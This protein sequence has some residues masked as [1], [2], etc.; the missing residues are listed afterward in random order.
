[1]TRYSGQNPDEQKRQ[2]QPT[3]C[4]FVIAWQYPEF[5]RMRVTLDTNA[6]GI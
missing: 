2:V 4:S 1:M 3:S 5:A 6:N